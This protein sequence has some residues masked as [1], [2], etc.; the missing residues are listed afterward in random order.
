[1]AWRIA[2][3]VVCGEIDN[4]TPGRVDGKVWLAGHDEP[5]V[6]QLTGNC[7]KDL[8]GCKLTFSNPAPKPDPG[9]P[10]AAD[11]SGVVGDMTAARKVRV[12][13]NFDYLAIKKGK[14][15]PEYTANCLYLE[16]F[17]HRNGRVVIESTDYEISVSEPLWRLSP[18][19]EL[20]QHEANAEAMRS[21]M[22][23]VAGALDPREEAAYEGSPQDEFEW[24]LFLRASDRRATKL[25]ELMEKYVD[26]P[27]RDRIIA[28]EMGWTHIEEM[29]DAEAEFGD[30][31]E[32][33]NIDDDDFD[34]PD[35]IDLDEE[36][37][38]H[39]LVARLME[40]SV[41][42]V[43]L[44]GNRQDNDLEEMV[45]GFMAVGPKIAGSLGIV[46]PNRQIDRE[47][48]GLVVARLKRALGDLSRAL[49]A[50]S[51]LKE[52]KLEL[53]FSIDE[54]VAEMLNTRQE[55]LS[56]MNEFRR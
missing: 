29:L 39:P 42:L 37:P 32:P 44:V 43:K 8:A 33:D 26:D 56:L 16:W 25:G 20:R 4:R 24:E 52:K 41:T 1:M 50:A 53:P 27:D 35:P 45:G 49:N 31:E 40:R 11:Q 14:K 13:E 36:R 47:L 9:F 21:F 46:R 30:E 19:E 48:K 5:L 3:S 28:R 10:P 23:R 55:I 54:W 17:S 15:F 34:E 2:D 6:L 38:R 12:I 7:H 22:E 51:R 18:D